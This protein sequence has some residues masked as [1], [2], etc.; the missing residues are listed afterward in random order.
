VPDRPKSLLAR[1]TRHAVLLLAVTGVLAGCST[2]SRSGSTSSDSADLP[3]SAAAALVKY[4]QYGTPSYVGAA[5]NASAAHGKTVWWVPNDTGNPF[6]AILG[7]NLTAALSSQGVKVTSCD[8]QNNPADTNGCINQ[9][10]A[11]HA[12]AIQ[13]DGAEPKTYATQI[14]AAKAA[15]IPIFSGAAVDASDPLFP[16]LTGQSSQAFKLL[17]KLMADWITKDSGGSAHVLAITVPDVAGAAAELAAF[18]SE[19]STVCPKCEVTVK[20]ITLANWATDLAPT[21]SAALISDPKLSYVVPMFD[22]MAQFTDP[23]IQQAG[24]SGSVKVVT[25]N[26]SLQQMQDLKSGSVVAA[27]VGD[28]LNA[29]G[30]I[31]ADLILRALNG[32]PQPA[33]FPVAPVRVFDESNVGNLG[34]TESAQAS[35]AWYTSSPGAYVKFFAKVWKG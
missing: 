16:G 19:S 7:Q 28:D 6:L 3:P 14:T 2:A 33:S 1:F 22:P 24:K 5:F 13:V 12:A 17:G 21:T 23:A 15:G 31:E 20:G 25:A 30:Y 29:Q 27:E 26:G 32:Q 18:E 10:I 11:Q 4:S 35:G 8:G 34:M 9:A